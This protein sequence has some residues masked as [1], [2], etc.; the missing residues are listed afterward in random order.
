MKNV[1]KTPCWCLQRLHYVEKKFQQFLALLLV[2]F[3]FA[4]GFNRTIYK[5]LCD[6]KIKQS[7]WKNN[8]LKHENMQTMVSLS[9]MCRCTPNKIAKADF[10]KLLKISSIWN[11]SNFADFM[12]AS[13]C[14]SDRTAF[15]V[16]IYQNKNLVKIV[17]K[18]TFG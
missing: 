4:P 7:V 14:F 6:L 9:T 17:A 1:P 16:F 3:F 15:I 8:F 12:K 10:L 5:R 18:K 2:N 13:N 11:L